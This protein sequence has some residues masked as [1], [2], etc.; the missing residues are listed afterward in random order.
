MKA[1]TMCCKKLVDVGKAAK[2]KI[3]GEE[4][5][6]CNDQC[7]KFAEMATPEQLKVMMAD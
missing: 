5:L 6:V 7:K 2:A 4:Y 1:R 3:K